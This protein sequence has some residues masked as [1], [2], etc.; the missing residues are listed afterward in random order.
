MFNSE[1]T[2]F[3]LYFYKIIT[4]RAIKQCGMENVMIGL[5][6][7]LKL[8]GRSLLLLILFFSRFNL[9]GQ[10]S[11]GST[12]G[13]FQVKGAKV[14]PQFQL[15]SVHV[16]E[17][18]MADK[19]L[20]IPN[21]YG[22]VQELNIDIR[23]EG[24]KTIIGDMLIWQYEIDCPD[25]LS[26]GITF[27]NYHLPKGAKVFIYNPDR[28][29]IRGGFT[30]L[31]NKADNQLTLGEFRGN[32]LIIEYDEP[33]D[34]EFNGVLVIGEI[35]KAYVNFSS[36]ALANVQINCSAGADWQNEKRA[37]CLMT[38]HDYAYSYYCSGALINNVRCDRTPYFLTANHCIG[39][40]T[41]A[42]TLV[43]YFNYENT[44]C[45]N[46]DASL[47][48]SLS[49]S[50]LVANSGYSDFCLLKLNEYPPSAYLPYY[51]G[52][53]A[54]STD[55]PTQGT[56]IHHPGGGTKSIAIDHNPF[57]SNNND[58]QWDNNS[59]SDVNTHW[60]VFYDVGSDAGGSSGSPL[61]DENK[62]IIGQL[63]GG[64]NISSLFGKF[65]LSW[66]YS[67]ISIRQL[68]R[69][70][71]PDDT[72]ILR[73]DGIDVNK[74]PEAH[75][76]SDVTDACLNTPVTLTDKSKYLP[77]NWNWEITPST[78]EFVDGTSASSQNPKVI[79]LTDGTY[80][81]SLTVGNEIGTNSVS[82]KNLILATS[83]LPVAFREVSNEMT[84]CGYLLKNYRMVADGA[85]T[86]S[87]NLTTPENFDVAQNADSLTL[88]LKDEARQ[89]GSF[90][91][92]VKVTGSHGDCSSSDSV[93][94]HVIMPP[95]D[96]VAYALD[97]KLGSNPTFSNECG[98]AQTNEPNPPMTGCFIKN[99]WCP[100]ASG[101]PLIYNSVW[102]KFMGPSNGKITI[103]TQGFDTQIAVYE[104]N[105]AAALLSGDPSNYT[106]VAANDNL[107]SGQ[108]N[109]EIE[110]LPVMPGKTYWLQVNGAN[111]ASGDLNVNLL[112][113]T[114]EV[115][116]NP[117]NGI[118]HLTVSSF[119][120]G[121]AQLAV[122]T[123]TGQQILSK[124]VPVSLNSN[125]VDLDLSSFRSG[126]YLFRTNINGLVMAKKLLLKK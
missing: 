106:L 63:H 48:Q 74:A 114:I 50:T 33:F 11:D 25:A 116:P 39:T 40:Q 61:F 95:N 64:N 99:N 41:L 31:N 91:T 19:N 34:A 12:P 125:T 87:F 105:S 117:S 32:R 57:T 112:D 110:D 47:S 72:Q 83:K 73:L 23:S 15:D 16:A 7:C 59:F 44:T 107:T 70:L 85:S 43:T 76:V 68:K 115:Y 67:S 96:D 49:G 38:F 69:W 51:A 118:F 86:Y 66:N 5:K 121:D 98:T 75:F 30:S 55:N 108:T 14:V 4:N 94:L 65:S 84:V 81:I 17:K 35:S 20:G 52:W 56:C 111:G 100:R 29:I 104:A 46:Y 10:I 90:D 101:T 60:E 8:L 36:V 45:Y 62:R 13:S 3:L 124:T 22:V 126:L 113:N 78:F 37:V 77:T 97:L 18:I 109:A 103:Q 80:S 26:L 28:T 27:K 58:V 53:N 120:G 21:R 89:H 42:N 71:D 24:I 122:F 123:L 119:R 2:I 102:F 6:P 9:Y 92:Y 93:L 54:S 82:S 88:T 79:F 1:T